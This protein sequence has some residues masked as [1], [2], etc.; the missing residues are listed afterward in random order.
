MRKGREPTAQHAWAMDGREIKWA[1]V[2]E[3]SKLGGWFR[4]Q[5]GDG[6]TVGVLASQLGLRTIPKRVILQKRR[7]VCRLIFYSLK[8]PDG[9]LTSVLEVCDAVFCGKPAYQFT[10]ANCCPAATNAKAPRRSL[11]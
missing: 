5:T 8:Q 1:E 6:K 10:L 3:E 4:G 9:R 2:K 11:T 7:S